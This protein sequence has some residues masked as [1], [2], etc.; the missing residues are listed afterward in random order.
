MLYTSAK[1]A[2]LAVL[3]Q[4]KGEAKARVKGMTDAMLAEGFG[5]CTNHYECQEACPKGISVKF[6]AKLNREYIKS[7]GS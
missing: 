6:I 1:V 4:G 5:N 3:P 7:I 2:Q